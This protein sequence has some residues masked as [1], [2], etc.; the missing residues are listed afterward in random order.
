VSVTGNIVETNLIVIK[1]SGAVVDHPNTVTGIS[2][3]Q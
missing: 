3:L 1:N 2:K